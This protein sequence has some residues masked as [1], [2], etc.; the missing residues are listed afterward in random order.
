MATIIT[1]AYPYSL[2]VIPLAMLRQGRN[3]SLKGSLKKILRN[4]ILVNSGVFKGL[5]LAN[6]FYSGV[7]W[8]FSI[9][10]LWFSPVRG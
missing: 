1:L 3:E 8:C 10:V 2:G 7:L 4:T 6:E 9:A 5:Y